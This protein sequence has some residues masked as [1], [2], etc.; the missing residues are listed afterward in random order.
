MDRCWGKQKAHERKLEEAG[1]RQDLGQQQ[2]A[3]ED[4][5]SDISV[6]ARLQVAVEAL[7]EFERAKV[8]WMD[9][10]LQAR[11]ISDGDKCTQLFF[12][13]FKGLAREKEILQAFDEQGTIRTTW[14][15]IAEA[16]TSFFR[17]FLGTRLE[18]SKTSSRLS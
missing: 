18:L 6:Q 9:H 17:I 12:K 11:W 4:N 2:Q 14:E 1:L 16:A 5:P 10:I 7:K 13:S 3:L 8:E 15:D